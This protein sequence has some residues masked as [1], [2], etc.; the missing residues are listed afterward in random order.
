VQISERTLR[1]LF[2]GLA[3]LNVGLGVWLFFF[4]HS[5]YTTIGAFEAYNRHYERDVATFYFAFALGTW[6]AARHASWRA[7]VLAM[8]T[9]QYLLHTINHGIDS[10]EANNSWAGPV[11]FVS[12]ALGTVQFAALLWL[13]RTRRSVPQ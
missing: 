13:L 12:L 7:P 9:L 8:L 3:A 2:L 6:G 11:D 10:G 4:P 5:F 1:I